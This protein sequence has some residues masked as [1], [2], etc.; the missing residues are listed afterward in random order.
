MCSIC[1]VKL[2]RDT[3]LEKDASQPNLQPL[4]ISV[5][6]ERDSPKV[7]KDYC[8]EYSPH[9]IGFT[10]SEEEIREVC[11]KFRV[12][13]GKGERDENNDY[14]VDHTIIIYL[15]NPRGEFVNYFGRSLSAD[16]VYTAVA[17]HIARYNEL[18]QK[19][20]LDNE[21]DQK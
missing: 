4:F 13:F 9:L 12:Y 11:K 8:S 14:I 17:Q 15:L 6:P 10:G 1:S 20:K 16:N 7:I 21:K 3:A 5:D 18:Q 19:G 2:M